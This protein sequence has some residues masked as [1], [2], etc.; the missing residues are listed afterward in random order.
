[1]VEVAG[2]GSWL[3]R[4]SSG[5]CRSKQAGNSATSSLLAGLGAGVAGGR[6][7]RPHDRESESAPRARS[8]GRR[9]FGVGHS[10]GTAPARACRR[11]SPT[12]GDLP[13]GARTPGRAGAAKRRV[14]NPGITPLFTPNRSFYF[15]DTAFD[16]A[17]TAPRV[18]RD[19]WRLRVHGLVEH[20]L[21]FSLQELLAMELVE[22]D[23]TLVCGNNPVGGNRIGSAR[24]LGALLATPGVCAPRATRC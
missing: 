1:M 24:W 6:H 14:R 8:I 11:R 21:E 10:R 7:P 16:T 9:R 5:G 4:D 15:T 17:L 19:R 18:D 13:A 23:A 22:V 12:R 3:A 20:A 2:S